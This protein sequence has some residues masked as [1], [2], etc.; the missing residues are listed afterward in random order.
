MKKTSTDRAIKRLPVFYVIIIIFALAIAIMLHAWIKSPEHD[1]LNVTTL[2]IEIAVGIIISWTVYIFSKKWKE[3]NDASTKKI[4][5]VTDYLNT[6][7]KGKERYASWVMNNKLDLLKMEYNHIVNSLYPKWQN[8]TDLTRKN[9]FYNSMR[10][11]FDRTFEHLKLVSIPPLELRD[12]FEDN[13][14][15]MIQT[16]FSKVS[17]NSSLYFDIGGTIEESMPSFINH[18]KECQDIVNNLSK[19]ISPMVSS[20]VKGKA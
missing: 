10:S 4:K 13:I 6:R 18:V 16:M 17:I 8:E 14:S 19:V 2:V 3:E 12:I 7:L 1:L 20:Y 11:S 9:N 5:E 15:G